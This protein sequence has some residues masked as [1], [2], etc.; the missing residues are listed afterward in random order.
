MPLDENFFSNYLLNFSNMMLV[1]IYVVLI[2]TYMILA[3]RM[4][5]S[6]FAVVGLFVATSV[7]FF[8][9]ASFTDFYGKDTFSS[10]GFVF[11][12]LF[13]VLMMVFVFYLVRIKKKLSRRRNK[14]Q[15][16]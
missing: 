5:Y 16:L 2:A 11:T 3:I 9:L 15:L 6:V 4:F 1:A 8:V 14:N 13:F 10:V 7:V 12:F